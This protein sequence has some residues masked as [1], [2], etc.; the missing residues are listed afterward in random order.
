MDSR[1]AF[2]GG[3]NMAEALIKGLMQGLAVPPARI[4]ATDI[5]PERRHYLEKTY[6]IHTTADNCQAVR[7]HDVIILAVKPQHLPEVLATI[8]PVVTRQH[9]VISI[10]AGVPLRTLQAALGEEVRLVRVMPN[11]PA[12]VLAGAAGIA[13]GKAATAE[14]VALVER[15]FS[16]VGRA[17]VVGD[18][19]MD[20]VTGLSGSGP[21]FVFAVI[22]ALA[23]GG[24]LVGLPRQ[25]AVVLA[26]QTVLG[27]AKLVLETGKHPGELKDMVASP[28]G[29]TIAGLHALERGGL[30]GLLMD[31]VRL[32]TERSAALG[33]LSDH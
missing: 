15:V 2:I 16:A 4:T 12:L 7:E 22:E 5:L 27:A 23:D 30:R 24:V 13:P 8:A 14:D 10:A 21:A 25:M 6:G 18:E 11:T 33:R 26:A 17:V 1:F 28:A 29:T 20:A 32:A 19:L 31:A 3:G 9:L